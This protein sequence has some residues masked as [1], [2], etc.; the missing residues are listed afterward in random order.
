MIKQL[1]IFKYQLKMLMMRQLANISLMFAVLLVYVCNKCI[2][3]SN[4]FE[5][6]FYYITDT[7]V[8]NRKQPC[9]VYSDL[10]IS[11][12]AAIVI[13]YLVYSQRFTTEVV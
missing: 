11:R 2:N 6:F 4:S 12:A 10:G 8:K 7:N 3:I 1:I 13:A 5:I 9:L